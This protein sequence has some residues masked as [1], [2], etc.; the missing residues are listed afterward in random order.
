MIFKDSTEIDKKEKEKTTVTVAK[1]LS[2]TAWDYL[3]GFEKFRGR[4]FGF[5]VY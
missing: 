5:I 2:K 1:P 4:K 3:P